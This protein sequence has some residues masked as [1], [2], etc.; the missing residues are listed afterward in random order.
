MRLSMDLYVSLCIHRRV[1]W[2]WCCGA[3]DRV[4]MKRAQ[5]GCSL[6]TPTSSG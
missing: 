3:K 5:S 4:Q 6:H 1:T 2:R